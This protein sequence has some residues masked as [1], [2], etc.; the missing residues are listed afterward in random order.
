[1]AG[2]MTNQN[3]FNEK[4]YNFFKWINTDL[5]YVLDQ[6]PEL[7]NYKNSFENNSV[8]FMLNMKAFVCK[9]NI[10]QVL[11]EFCSKLNIDKNKIKDEHIL[12]LKR[13]LSMFSEII[14]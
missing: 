6:F 13:Y 8:S 3:L 11:N 10:D 1:M 9:K 4:H 5:K 12:K 14:L 2:F 7:I